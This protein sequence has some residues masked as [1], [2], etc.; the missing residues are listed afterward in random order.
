MWRSRV[1]S[2]GRQLGGPPTLKHCTKHPVLTPMGAPL[3]A[4]T[5]PSLNSSLGFLN[6]VQA[7]EM[8]ALFIYRRTQ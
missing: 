7:K 8:N 4:V 5:A 2:G 3:T 1:E 6:K